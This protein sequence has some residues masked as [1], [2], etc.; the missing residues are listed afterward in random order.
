MPKRDLFHTRSKPNA[1]DYRFS[2]SQVRMGTRDKTLQSWRGGPLTRAPSDRCYPHHPSGGHM[3]Q[4]PNIESTAPA[5]LALSPSRLC[6]LYIMASP[7]LW[8]NN[9]GSI[10]NECLDLASIGVRSYHR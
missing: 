6:T 9:D 8:R 7:Y 4:S 10:T 3:R 1:E 5:T 2:G